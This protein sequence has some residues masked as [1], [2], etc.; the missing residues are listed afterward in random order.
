MKYLLLTLIFCFV[1][2]EK[3]YAQVFYDLNSN[4]NW[5][6]VI[7]R[8]YA[9]FKSRD[10]LNY[11]G[12]FLIKY[13]NE[14]IAC[15]ARDFTGTTY[16]PGKM[17]FIKDFNKELLSWKMYLPFEP[18]KFIL[19]DSLVLKERIEKQWF[20]FMYSRSF[21]TFSIK[22]IDNSIIPLEPNITRN[23]N[24]DTVYLV[25]YDDR[26][27]LKLV[28]GIIE[29]ADKSKYADFELRIKTDEY[30]YYNNFVGSPIINKD[31]KAIGIFNRAYRLKFNKRGNIINDDKLST[32]SY[33][34]YFVNGIT[35]RSMLGKNYCK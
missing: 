11:G 10:N 35:M 33:F 2:I 20:V 16:T 31:G 28:R 14:I 6:N 23:R 25:G 5:K 32:D 19:T 3:Q 26:N 18:L 21:L 13:N 27:N 12:A 34:E 29:T 7:L 8:N 15:T 17:L 30:L 22:K 24:K 1:F 4:L 9:T